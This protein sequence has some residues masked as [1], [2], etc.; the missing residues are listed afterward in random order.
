MC[1]N[2]IERLNSELNGKNKRDSV[3]HQVTKEDESAYTNC[4]SDKVLIDDH[5][6]ARSSD[7]HKSKT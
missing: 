4:P 7:F 6:K 3:P 1:T 5:I 2:E